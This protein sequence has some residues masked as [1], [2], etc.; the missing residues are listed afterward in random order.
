MN[1]SPSGRLLVMEPDYL[2]IPE[3]FV[4]AMIVPQLDFTIRLCIPQL[5]L[6]HGFSAHCIIVPVLEL[7][8]S[9]VGKHY[10]F[11]SWLCI[12]YWVVL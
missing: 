10:I 9:G 12:L 6:A 2:P 4:S 7:L 5:V 1:Q 3:I 8:V 11:V